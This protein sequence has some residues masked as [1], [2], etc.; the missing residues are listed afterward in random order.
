M[1]QRK[2][3]KDSKRGREITLNDKDSAIT[4]ALFSR[5][6][7]EIGGQ[8]TQQAVTISLKENYLTTSL[9][10]VFPNEMQINKIEMMYGRFVNQIDNQQS[11][12]VLV[13]SD[14]QARQLTSQ[15]IQQLIGQHVNVGSF[16]FSVVGIYKKD[17]TGAMMWHIRPSI[18]LEQYI[19]RGIRPMNCI[20]LFMV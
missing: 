19:T 3:I 16:S 11:R 4:G 6:V 8:V 17:D 18:R 12:K 13:I 7:D 2:S 20:L 5:H 15:D 10:G 1:R 9:S 14:E